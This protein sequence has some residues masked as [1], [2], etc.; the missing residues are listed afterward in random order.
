MQRINA[1]SSPRN[2]S[3]A[4]MYAFA[5]RE[6]MS[7]VDEPLYAHY[8]VKTKSLV[9]HPAT[10]E[11]I[12]TQENDGEKVIQDV[13]FGDHPTPA[14]L[15]KQMTHHL[16]DISTDFLAKTDNILLIRDPRYIINSYIK[17]IP[18]P[19]ISDIGVKDQ[20]SL[21][22]QLKAVGTLKAVVDSKEL[23]LDPEK[24]LRQLCAKLDLAFDA[25]MLQWT[26]G[27]RPE[28]G[29]WAKHWYANVHKSTGFQPYTPQKISL[30][31]AMEKLAEECMPYYEKLFDY[32]IKAN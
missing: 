29:V 28:D 21:F 15:F 23:L 30:P 32:A 4:F 6:D 10:Q 9:H 26:A 5:Q 24:V 18:N 22:K 8:L 12:T 7:V 3:T 31:P 27:P 13:I 20:L 19:T 1:W 25:S 11:V 17:V 2:I 16:I 14:V